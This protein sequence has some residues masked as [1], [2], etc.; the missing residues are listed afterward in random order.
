MSADYP[1]AQE[2]FVPRNFMFNSNARKCL[3]IHK[4]GGDA[5]PQAVYNTFINS[6]NPGKSSHYAIGQDG[7]IW[8]F[9]PESLGAGANGITDSTTEAF[10]HPYIQEYGNLNECTISIEHC[11]PSPRNDTPLT[12]AQKQ[13][14]FALVAHLCQKYDIAADHIKPHKSICAT[15]CPG[16]YP[17]DELISY[18]QNGGSTMGVPTG[19]KD[20][21]KTLTAPNGVPVVQGFRE[22][23]L[24]NNWDAGNVPLQPEAGRNPLED[25]NPSLGGGTWQPFRWTVLEW[26]ADRGVFV[27]WCGQELAYMRAHPPTSVPAPVDTTALVA[28]INAIPDAIA[29]VVAA[30]IVQAKKL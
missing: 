1:A 22:Y 30:A 27:A 16:T 20:D 15:A 12:A 5:T 7:S 8:Q 3:V 4:T 13:A 9:V 11:D 29:P 17:M 26:T 6:G 10:W 2:H 19:W 14:S 18:V 21:G 28:A 24:E 23:V 25:S